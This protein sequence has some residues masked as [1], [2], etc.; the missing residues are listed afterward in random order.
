MD[1]HRKLTK[2]EAGSLGALAT[3]RKYGNEYYAHMKDIGKKGYAAVRDTYARVP[4]G[5]SQWALVHRVTG[6]IKAIWS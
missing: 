4:Y 2:Q 5:T 1:N 3:K 6:E